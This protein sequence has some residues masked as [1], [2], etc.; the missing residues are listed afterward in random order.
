MEN[1]Q[2]GNLVPVAGEVRRHSSTKKIEKKHP[3]KYRTP[4]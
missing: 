2:D 3:N 1:R 4:I